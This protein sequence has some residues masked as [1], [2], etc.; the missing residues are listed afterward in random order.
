MTSMI[1][2]ADHI[3]GQ[4]VAPGDPR[5]G[6]LRVQRRVA[7]ARLSAE[8]HDLGHPAR[9]SRAGAPLEANPRRLGKD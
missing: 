5:R 8:C 4:V 1:S 7:G 9:R 2:L 6:Q 3:A